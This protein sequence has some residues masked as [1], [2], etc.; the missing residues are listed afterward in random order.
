[1]LD[2]TTKSKFCKT[3]AHCL[4]WQSGSVISIVSVQQSL[5][6]SSY[7]SMN[8][9]GVLEASSLSGVVC[10]GVISTGDSEACTL[11]KISHP[12]FH[13]ERADCPAAKIQ[14]RKALIAKHVDMLMWVPV[15]YYSV[16]RAINLMSGSQWFVAFLPWVSPLRLH[17]DCPIFWVEVRSRKWRLQTLLK[18]EKSPSPPLNVFQVKKNIYLMLILS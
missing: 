8:F 16:F 10:K 13:T 6:C 3:S 4:R 1:M 7:A 2:N 18:A 17:A 12:H 14:M 5:T 9:F 11:H 15:N